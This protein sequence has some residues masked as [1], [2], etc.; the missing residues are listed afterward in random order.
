MR[1]SLPVAHELE[2]SDG[3]E[4][5]QEEDGQQDVVEVA[6]YSKHTFR[7]DVQRHQQVDDNDDHQ[8]DYVEA[9][10]EVQQEL[11]GHYEP[12]QALQHVWQ[13]DDSPHNRSVVVESYVVVPHFLLDLLCVWAVLEEPEEHAHALPAERALDLLVMLVVE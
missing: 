2:G 7:E 6:D 4:E 5:H 3:D 8:P 11:A 1:C 10:K 9:P 13:F 12:A